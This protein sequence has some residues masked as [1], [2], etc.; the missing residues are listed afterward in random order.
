MLF[1]PGNQFWRYATNSGRDRIIESPEQLWK[2]AM[3]Y[4]QMCD[5]NP[6]LEVDYRG[7]DAVE[8]VLPKKK[9]YQ[10]NEFALFCGV[11]R[12]Q[13]IDRYKDYSPEFCDTITRIEGIIWAQNFDGAAAG[14]FK[15]GLMI[16]NLGL[17]DMVKHESVKAISVQIKTESDN[18]VDNTAL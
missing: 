14:F 11:S 9:P 3:E 18:D 12:W 10:K 13:T 2:M 5:A 1:Q 16:R 15:E 4:F 7:K 17:T 8:V 6:L